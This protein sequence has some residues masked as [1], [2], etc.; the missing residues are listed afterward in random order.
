MMVSI[1]RSALEHGPF[2]TTK[3]LDT[4]RK[5]GVGTGGKDDIF[6]RSDVEISS[7]DTFLL[8]CQAQL[9]SPLTVEDGLISDSDVASFAST[10]CDIF[11]ADD[12]PAFA[13]P[14]PLFSNLATDVK[15][16]FA[17]YICPHQSELSLLQCLASMSV[18]EGGFG[19][20]I[21]E[22]SPQPAT[23]NVLGF[24]CSLLQFLENV[25]IDPLFGE[26]FAQ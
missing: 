15:M 22:E 6:D 23:D 19:Y 4:I 25:G 11:E 16:S 2:D 10:L 21:S 5:L 26:C 9:L 8:Y 18:Q 12:I 13:C 7:E 17:W 24:C 1:K 3:N 20:P 14:D